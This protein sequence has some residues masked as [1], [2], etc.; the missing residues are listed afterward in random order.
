MVVTPPTRHGQFLVVL[1]GACAALVIA[2]AGGA[3]VGASTSF[4]GNSPVR[5]DQ[6]TSVMDRTGRYE[7]M[8]RTYEL[9]NERSDQLRR[10]ENS[11]TPDPRVVRDLK[12]E[13]AALAARL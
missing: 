10:E 8:R 9:M 2:A 5:V 12:S 3:G 7:R 1:A 11:A 6:A 13:L 4:T